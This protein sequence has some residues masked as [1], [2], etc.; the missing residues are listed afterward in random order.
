M[1]IITE[2]D[3]TNIWE[4][5]PAHSPHE[6]SKWLWLTSC[7]QFDHEEAAFD[8]LRFLV[9]QFN[10]HDLFLLSVYHWAKSLRVWWLLKTHLMLSL[11]TWLS[12]SS[13]FKVYRWVRAHWYFSTVYCIAENCVTQENSNF[14]L[15]NPASTS[16]LSL[17]PTSGST[18]TGN[19]C[20]LLVSIPEQVGS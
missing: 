7:Y 18:R 12:R 13:T 1:Q 4:R 16:G 11:E 9:L 10:A 15:T 20:P 17:F 14:Y 3:L 2:K 6:L 8:I 19:P 5:C